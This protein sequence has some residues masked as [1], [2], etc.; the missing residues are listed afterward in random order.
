MRVAKV[1]LYPHRHGSTI[2]RFT[3]PV[4]V[5]GMITNTVLA[6]VYD[7]HRHRIAHRNDTIMSPSQLQVYA[8]AISECRAPLENCFGFIDG[9]MRPTCCPGQNQRVVYNG[10]KRVHALK[11]QSV[12]PSK[13]RRWKC[14]WTHG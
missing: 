3:R 14:I 7:F 5:L 10:H 2:Q 13:R 1:H 6:Y 8:D 9:T 11:S 12:G 4:P